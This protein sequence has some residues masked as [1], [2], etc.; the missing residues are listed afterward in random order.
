MLNFLEKFKLLAKNVEAVKI[1][2]VAHS[3]TN[4][5]PPGCNYCCY[6]KTRGNF[7]VF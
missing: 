4:V 6:Y 7:V 3:N 1:K 5:F 2:P